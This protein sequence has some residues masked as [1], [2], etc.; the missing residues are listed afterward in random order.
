MHWNWTSF[1]PCSN[2]YHREHMIYHLI[3][4]CFALFILNCQFLHTPYAWPSWQQSLSQ[5]C[6]SHILLIESSALQGRTDINQCSEG[7]AWWSELS[8]L[9]ASSRKFS[10]L[11]SLIQA[12]TVMGRWGRHQTGQMA[13]PAPLVS[14]FTSYSFTYCF[15]IW[16][17]MSHRGFWFGWQCNPS[18]HLWMVNLL[19]SI[20]VSYEQPCL[21]KL[22]RLLSQKSGLKW[23][24]SVLFWNS[25]LSLCYWEPGKY[26][27]GNYLLCFNVVKVYIVQV[28]DSTSWSQHLWNI[29]ELISE[30]WGRLG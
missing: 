7:S 1:L 21:V 6:W 24:G 25:W 28:V 11:I 3:L 9:Q 16:L 20:N 29:L 10:H 17:D 27:F 13:M 18:V 30:K 22:G 15:I 5:V 2:P 8:F 19:F 12:A 14:V 23:N 4:L 26:W